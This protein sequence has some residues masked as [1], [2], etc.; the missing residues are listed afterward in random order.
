MNEVFN[1]MRL[2]GRFEVFSTAAIVVG[3]Q[4]TASAFRDAAG[5]PERRKTRFASVE[6]GIRFRSGWQ[7]CSASGS[8]WSG[9]L[10]PRGPMSERSTLCKAVANELRHAAEEIANLG[11][12]KAEMR[13]S[14]GGN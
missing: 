12:A 7:V 6:S 4:R 14:P 13:A 8:A 2:S 11:V 3:R 5:K 10:G 1:M 9:L